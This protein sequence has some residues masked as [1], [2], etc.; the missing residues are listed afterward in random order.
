M[1]IFRAEKVISTLPGS[2]E[3][4]TLYAVRV[5]DGFDLYI[6]DSTGTVAHK[7]NP[8]VAMGSAFARSTSTFSSSNNIPADNTIPQKT[9]GV[10]VITAPITAKNSLN[11]LLL[12]FTSYGAVSTSF[13][14][15]QWAVFRG[16]ES[17]AI[18][19]GQFTSD[20]EPTTRHPFT[21]HVT[22]PAGTTSATTYKVRIGA[23]SGTVY[24]NRDSGG[25]KYGAASQIF[26]SILEIAP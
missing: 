16:D 5:G 19:A 21:F 14:P 7:V 26:L 3:A 12:F 20:Q 23:N 18:A 25:L 2:L 10:E 15:T 17:D 6:S 9:E 13:Q 4:D 8:S 1:A 24:V 11:E 22:V